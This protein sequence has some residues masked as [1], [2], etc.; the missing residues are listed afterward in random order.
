MPSEPFMFFVPFLPFLFR[1]LESLPTTGVQSRHYVAAVA[2]T[3]IV[4]SESRRARS[5][6]SAIS[7]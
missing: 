5:N 4:S 1:L 2:E 6:A 3:T 7:S